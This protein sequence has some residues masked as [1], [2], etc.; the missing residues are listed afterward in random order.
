MFLVLGS[1]LLF[2]FSPV[3]HSASVAGERKHFQFKIPD[4]LFHSGDLIFRDGK[5]F[6]S[7]AFRK[8]SLT[9]P[10]YSHAGI[11]HRESNN[12]FVYHII[13]GEGK[14]NSKMR[15]EKLADFCSSSLSDGFAVFR[16]DLKGAAIDS[17]AGYYYSK[18]ISFDT[19]FNLDTDD[20]MYCTELLYKVLEKVSGRNNFITLTHLSGFTYVACDNIYM[21]LHN[22]NIYSY[23]S[24]K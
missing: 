4:S 6:I 18:K 17:L 3:S 14:L 20:K 13:G 10:H 11:I 23:T 12:L 9:D 19:D 5:G 8:L 24:L 7:K 15:K 22:K 1:T 21:S 16:T 2:S